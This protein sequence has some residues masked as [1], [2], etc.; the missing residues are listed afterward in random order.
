[1]K[2]QT[3]G[4]FY[5]SL[6]GI[7]VSKHNAIYKYLHIKNSYVTTSSNGE[8]KL[9]QDPYTIKGSFFVTSVIIH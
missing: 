8:K 2:I 1:M 6:M 5:V 4:Q 9:F 3:H 7:I